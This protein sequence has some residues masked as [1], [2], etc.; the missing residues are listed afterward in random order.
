[1]LPAGIRATMVAMTTVT[2]LEARTIGT[3]VVTVETSSDWSCVFVYTRW[4]AAAAAHE[5]VIS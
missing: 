4:L 2:M 1:M 3:R 5:A